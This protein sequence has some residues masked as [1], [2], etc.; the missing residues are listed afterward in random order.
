M[1]PLLNDRA[2]LS[3]DRRDD[4]LDRT[5][6][7]PMLR[8][9]AIIM[10]V[11]MVLSSASVIIARADVGTGTGLL[12]FAVLIGIAGLVVWLWNRQYRNPDD[13]LMDTGS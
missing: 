5:G 1:D 4:D 7:S 12:I 9:V 3:E 11:A 13:D 8:I 6:L 2:E 10:I